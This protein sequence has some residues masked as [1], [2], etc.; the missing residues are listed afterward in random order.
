[1][2]FHFM[3]VYDNIR[4]E[5]FNANRNARLS[6]LITFDGAP[7]TEFNIFYL[8]DTNH[9]QKNWLWQQA[10]IYQWFNS[11]NKVDNSIITLYTTLCVVY[12]TSL[13]QII[14]KVRLQ[15]WIVDFLCLQS[16][17]R[18]KSKFESWKLLVCL[19]CI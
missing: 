15:V 6:F 2:T 19:F 3:D 17:W 16:V 7:N 9:E 4:N 1:M 12:E 8:V 11:N 10:S 5:F 13:W 18:F 14:P